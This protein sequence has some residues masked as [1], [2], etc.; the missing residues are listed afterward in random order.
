MKGGFDWANALPVL[1]GVAEADET[2]LV[3]GAG[4]SAE[5]GLP[6]WATLLDRLLLRA[7]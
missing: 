7:A 6:G 2:T 5:A 1:R 4:T 3:V